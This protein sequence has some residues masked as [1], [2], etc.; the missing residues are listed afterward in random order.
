[1]L[2]LCRAYILTVE[3]E[4]HPR[5]INS[6][7]QAAAIGCEY[8][9][10]KGT[11]PEGLEFHKYYSKLKNLFL[12]KRSLSTGEICC[13]VGHRRVWQQFLDDNIDYAIIFEDDFKIEDL[14]KLIASI[15][16]CIKFSNDWDVIKFFDY[17]P[18]EIVVSKNAGG[19]EIVAYKYPASGSVGYVVNRA[20]AKSLLKRRKFFRPVDEDMAFMWEFN[21]RIWSVIPNPVSETSHTLGGSSLEPGRVMTKRQRVVMRSIWGNVLQGWK[22]YK[23]IQYRKKM[24]AT[25][26]NP[27][28]IA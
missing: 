19:T 14:Q 23:S 20:A 24:H 12:F 17:R 10:V 3:D 25:A 13:Y 2:D 18:K 21:I 27:E 9:F 28:P 4:N 6:S 5:V 22:L 8:Q 11:K 7:S 26:Q 15:N 1:M 16:D